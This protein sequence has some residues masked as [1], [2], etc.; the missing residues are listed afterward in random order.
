MNLLAIAW[1]SVK[2]RSLASALTGLSIALG[3]MMMVIVLVIAG[4]V[5]E[6]FNQRSIAY[7]LIVG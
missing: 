6:T 5:D 1:K 2:Q 4:A 3:V 7:H